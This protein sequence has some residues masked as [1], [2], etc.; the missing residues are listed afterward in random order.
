MGILHSL[1]LLE[2][3]L[4][5]IRKESKFYHLLNGEWNFRYFESEIDIP[6]QTEEW[7]TILVPSC[8]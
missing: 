6:D 4:K 7:D 2:K 3:A 1:C 5:G 8:W